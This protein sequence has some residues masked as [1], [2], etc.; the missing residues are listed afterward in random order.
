[1]IN[2]ND[3]YKFWWDVMVLC[4]AIVICYLLPV[5]LAFKP[6]FGHSTWWYA[7]EYGIEVIFGIDVLVHFNTSLYDEDGN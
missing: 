4:L 5:Y 2:Y 3:P 6:S 1:M 7:V